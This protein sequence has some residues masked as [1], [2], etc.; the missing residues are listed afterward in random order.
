MKQQLAVLAPKA[1]G[2]DMLRKQLADLES[3]SNSTSDLMT[4]I[5]AVKA[6]AQP[7]QSQRAAA[8]AALRLETKAPIP[9]SNL[10]NPGPAPASLSREGSMERETPSPRHF[11]HDRKFSLVRSEAQVAAPVVPP[12]PPL[13]RG[14]RISLGTTLATAALF[15]RRPS[16][17]QRE[18]LSASCGGV[19]SPRSGMGEGGDVWSAEGRA[20]L[21]R[22][23][24]S[25]SVDGGCAERESGEGRVSLQ[26]VT[27]AAAVMALDEAGLR[28]AVAGLELQAGQV[29]ELVAQVRKPVFHTSVSDSEMLRNTLSR[30][31]TP[32]KLPQRPADYIFTIE[33]VPLTLRMSEFVRKRSKMTII[34]KRVQENCLQNP[35]KNQQ[36]PAGNHPPKPT[37]LKICQT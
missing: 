32:L 4:Q 30:L 16:L 1:A 18:A 37:N 3:A 20:S 12:Q 11:V 23:R 5:A 17:Q 10:A 13:P 28:E 36:N 6:S 8:V 24:E 29:D 2:V 22:E 9:T 15:E 34:K 25:L 27:P 7:E 33:T 14:K 21:R 19:P 26:R 35:P 31:Y